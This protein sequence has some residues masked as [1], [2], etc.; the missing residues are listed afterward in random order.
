MSAKLDPCEQPDWDRFLKMQ[1][2]KD[3][4]EKM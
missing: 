4:E 3:V 2:E 1:R